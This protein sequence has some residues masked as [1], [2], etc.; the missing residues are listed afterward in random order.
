[1]AIHNHPALYSGGSERLDSRP[2]VQMYAQMAARKQAR[3]DAFDEYIRSLNKNVNSAG[4][5]NQDRQA[6]DEKLAAWQKY[7]MENR[8]AIRSRKGGADMQFQQ[9]YQDLLNTVAESKQEEEKK[10]PIV[11]ILLDPNKRDRIDEDGVMKS[12][13]TH[14]KP[15]WKKN[16]SGQW[17]RDQERKSID[18]NSFSFKPK[19]Y[20][21]EQWQ[22]YDESLTKAIPSDKTDIQLKVHPTDK[23]SQIESTSAT[24][25]PQK[26]AELGDKARSDFASDQSLAY[27]FKKTHPY[28]KWVKDNGKEFDKLNSAFKAAY[29]Q[30]ANIQDDD[31]LFAATRIQSRLQ[32]TITE[33]RIDNWGARDERNFA[34][35]KELKA[36]ESMYNKSEAAYREQLKT[37]G[38]A[39]ANLWVDGH[40]KGLVDKAN[41]SKGGIH[42][43][44]DGKDYVEKELP[45]DP[46][47]KNSLRHGNVIPDYVTVTKDGKLRPV[48]LKTGEKQDGKY[49][50]DAILSQPVELE[51]A[52][53]GLGKTSGVKHLNEEMSGSS[54]AAPPSQTK[55][56]TIK[57]KK[58]YVT[59]KG[60][61]TIE[62]L[63]KHYTDQQIEDYI[64]KGALK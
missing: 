10:K 59:P 22:K 44:L 48:F 40:M 56:T 42:F 46:I 47:L 43:T 15:I 52:K 60:N 20:T 26:L 8:D 32:P 41:A 61:A 18:Y 36:L 24:Y 28:E 7:G 1:M 64:K 23:Y 5:R 21:P 9:Q 6:F 19:M 14:D 30:D 63:R 62:E 37:A 13:Q 34:Q 11:E 53:L 12:V 57:F 39:N 49:K 3:E 17:E 55:T 35:A 58:S 27:T 51:S 33:K 29:G 50:F 4:L 38:E 54:S 16:E 25:S 31:D 2:Y 45:N